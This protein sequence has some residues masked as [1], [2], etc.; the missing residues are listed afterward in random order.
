[1]SFAQSY[2]TSG[3][4]HLEL[5]RVSNGLTLH[6]RH[7]MTAGQAWAHGPWGQESGFW[8]QL[9][10]TGWSPLHHS[11]HI[12]AL[13]C[14]SSCLIK[15]KIT[16]MPWL[17]STYTVNFSWWIHPHL[18]KAKHGDLATDINAR[19][20]NAED[21]LFLQSLLGVDGASGDSSR[22]SRRHCNGHDIQAPDH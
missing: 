4:N 15:G 13:L 10:E 7:S 2:P 5:Q 9:W 16:L 8:D 19:W 17:F 22:Q 18:V 21:A 1:M 12:Q 11:P 14:E 6:Q 20:T 3:L